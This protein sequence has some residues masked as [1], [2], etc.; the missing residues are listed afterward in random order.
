[1]SQRPPL[2]A[3]GPPAK[4]EVGGGGGGGDN[5][6]DL[7]ASPVVVVDGA[8]RILRFNGACERLTGRGRGEV[9]GRHFGDVFQTAA[10]TVAGGAIE[11]TCQTPTGARHVTWVR[12]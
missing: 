1:M 8:D 12:A 5:L 10:A 2:T 11:T 9:V 3:G 4:A 7:V 6:L